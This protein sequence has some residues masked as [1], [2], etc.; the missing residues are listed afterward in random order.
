MLI[1]CLLCVGM[2]ARNGQKTVQF[3]ATPVNWN[4]SIIFE[5]LRSYNAYK[6]KTL[7]GMARLIQSFMHLLLLPLTYLKCVQPLNR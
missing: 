3:G 7:P 5:R 1:G 6:L 4:S 2:T